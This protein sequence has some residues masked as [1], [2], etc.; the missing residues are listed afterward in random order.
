MTTYEAIRTA[1]VQLGVDK[2]VGGRI[3]PDMAFAYDAPP[4]VVVQ[5][6]SSEPIATLD[7]NLGY[8]QAFTLEVYAATRS[9]ALSLANAIQAIESVAVE[10]GDDIFEFVCDDSSDEAVLIHPEK[11]EPEYK[12]TLNVT[13]FHR[14]GD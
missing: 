8:Q 6:R 13:V 11:G 12:T 3:R 14:H 10:D 1:L 5:C 7:A 4:L 9:E 2:L